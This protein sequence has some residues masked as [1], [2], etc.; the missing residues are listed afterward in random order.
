MY[1]GALCQVRQAQVLWGLS[2]FGLRTSVLKRNQNTEMQVEVP[3]GAA[4]E[5]PAS[6]APGREA[7]VHSQGPTPKAARQPWLLG[8]TLSHTH[9]H[10]CARPAFAAAPEAGVAP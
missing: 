4:L 8:H 3:A 7:P 5:A 2:S 6:E 9:V 1:R 10:T